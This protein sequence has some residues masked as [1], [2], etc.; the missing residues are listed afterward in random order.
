MRQ[1]GFPL[2]YHFGYVVFHRE[3]QGSIQT[4][5]LQVVIAFVLRNAPQCPAAAQTYGDRAVAWRLKSIRI[6]LRLLDLCQPSFA[7]QIGQIG[8]ERAAPAFQH[9]TTQA[10]S[11]SY[12]E[13]PA[14]FD[15][16]GYRM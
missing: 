14:R 13:P 9:V 11:F 8:S 16:A 2:G 7:R 15:I 12:E 5:Q 1:Q 4:M 3:V 6:A 10:V